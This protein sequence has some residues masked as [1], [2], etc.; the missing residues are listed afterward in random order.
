MK[1][2]VFP[3]KN[4]SKVDL[5][6]KEL[7]TIPIEVFELKNLRKLILHN[8]NITEIPKEISNLKLLEVLDLSNNKISK[9]YTKFCDLKGLRIL[10]LRNNRIEV[11]PKQIGKLEKLRKLDLSSNKIKSLPAEFSM[12]KNLISLNL[13]N[14][15]ITQLPNP[16][17]ELSKIKHLWICNL[18][19]NKLSVPVILDCFKFLKTIH[20]FSKKEPLENID[21]DYLT[22]SKISGNAKSKMLEIN[23][24]YLDK[25]YE[26]QTEKQSQKK[27]NQPL[28]INISAKKKF[29]IS[30]SKFDEDYKNEFVK[31][32]ITLK[33]NNQ[34]EAFNCDE[35]ELGANS[36]VVIQKK[37][38]ECDYMIALVSV[39]YLNTKYIREFEV[40]KAKE[41]GKKIIPIII[42]PCD[43]EASIIKNFHAALRGTNISLDRALFL[44]D[45]FKET[46]EIE[47]HAWW[48]AIVKEFRTKIFNQ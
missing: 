41:L 38:N 11:L 39:E 4:I 5:S 35:I 47:R 7:K 32:L 9:V 21:V 3:S 28:E 24:F 37:L 30:Y 25:Q 31:H 17:F 14:N 18:Q 48:T 10:I 27:L 2:N 45:K 26:Y 6:N 23:Q 43:W 33:D 46:T 16:I 20:A 40:E 34:V 44:K 19:L 1:K 12:L 8:N 13:S 29:F 36:H 42:K 22:L 15:L